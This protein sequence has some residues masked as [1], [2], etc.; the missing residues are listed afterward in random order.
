MCL[1]VCLYSKF[2]FSYVRVCVFVRASVDVA[3]DRLPTNSSVIV[4]S[5][6]CNLVRGVSM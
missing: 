6:I 2:M 1:G 4:I 5:T 3:S